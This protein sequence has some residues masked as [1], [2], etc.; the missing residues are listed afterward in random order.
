MTDKPYQEEFK[1]LQEK[2]LANFQ[3]KLNEFEARLDS[4]DAKGLAELFHKLKGNGKTYGFEEFSN[5]AHLVDRHYKKNSPDFL[6]WAKIGIRLLRNLYSS[7]VANTKF[8]LKNQTDYKT[9]SE[10]AHS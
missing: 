2:Y 1:K 4:N 6:H 9:L 8:D 3:A 10:S 5:I 7:I